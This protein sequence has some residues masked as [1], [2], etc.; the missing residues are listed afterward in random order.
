MLAR[1]IVPRRGLVM[2]LVV[3]SCALG[4]G[5]LPATGEQTWPNSYD[6]VFGI[7]LDHAQYAEGDPI[8]VTTVCTNAGPQ[9]LRYMPVANMGS[10]ECVAA[11]SDGQSFELTYPKPALP[12]G[13][14]SARLEPGESHLY[15]YY[16]HSWLH[17]LLPPG[18]YLM[19]A[20]MR[21]PFSYEAEAFLPDEAI[22]APVTY[23][24]NEVPFTVLQA[25]AQVPASTQLALNGDLLDAA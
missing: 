25:G 16:F 3:A 17:P 20:T 5:A 9:P 10:F 2:L 4:F 14:H 21:Q 23:T 22:A 19:R 15:Q 6:L 18:Q 1:I 11:R 7:M 12:P 13:D 8:Y 24:S